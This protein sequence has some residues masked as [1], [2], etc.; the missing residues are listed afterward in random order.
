MIIKVNAGRF[1]VPLELIE[2]GKNLILKFKFN[3]PLLEEIKN[4]DGARW[5]PD[6]KHWTILNN[7]RNR[8]Q[9]DYLQGLNPYARYDAPLVEIAK[10]QRY[11]HFEK[12]WCDVYEHQLTM[13]AHGI[14]RHY[15]MIAGEMGTGKTLSAIE[16]IERSGVS[17]CWWIGPKSALRSVELDFE[18]WGAKTTPRFMTYDEL[19]KVMSNWPP[20]KKAPQMVIFDESARIKTPTAQRSESAM[21]L[22]EG[23]RADWGDQGYVVEMTGT[24]AP[25]SPIDWWHQCEVACPGFLKEGNIHKFKNKLAVIKQESNTITGGM[26]PRIITWRDSDDKC[27][28][29]GK[30]RS[31]IM[32]GVMHAGSH[33]YKPMV[34]EVARL[35]KRMQGLV[36]VMF[37]KDCLDLPEKQYQLIRLKP[38]ASV[39]RA[40]KLISQS[41]PRAI[42]A[43]T[44]LREL[45]DGFQYRD[46]IVGTEVCPLCRGERTFD[47]RVPR[48]ASHNGHET[49]FSEDMLYIGYRVEGVFHS[50]YAANDETTEVIKAACDKC[51]GT[52]EVNKI[53]RET[54]DVECPKVEAMVDLLEEHEDCARLVTYAGFTGSIDRVTNI[55]V[56]Q[57][58][59]FIRVDGRGW[60]TS[61]VGYDTPME[62]L[63]AFQDKKNDFKINFIGYPGSAGE[64]LTLT[65]S[66]TI[67]YYSNDFNGMAR[68]QSEDRIHR[69]GMD[70]NRGARIIDLIHLP[71][72]ELVLN[73]LKKKRELETMSMGELRN[74]LSLVMD[75]IP[76]R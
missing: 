46:K 59:D 25:K 2:D 47:T 22:A 41:A 34:N 64:G 67:V 31:D 44:L 45:S 14:T 74:V 29:C 17:D 56:G 6:K 35:Y 61:L 76:S 75:T 9:L 40:A 10:F 60:K 63:K 12:V 48:E 18:K 71:T 50:L 4:M 19:K 70:I 39:L 37:K 72:D 54:I 62:M 68:T 24:P 26:F 36:L 73:N 13:I 65:A 66:P 7:G 51:N 21:A 23:V 8:F 30:P 3:R 49:C 55:T 11:N 27:E 28:E 38:S 32:H 20:G 5:V 58:W 52:G 16:V 1:K 15:C 57:G 42:T 43:L 69:I 53:E 33:A